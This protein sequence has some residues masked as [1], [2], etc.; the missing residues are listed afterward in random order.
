M[1]NESEIVTASYNG[2]AQ[3][4]I[5]FIKNEIIINNW[6]TVNTADS[7]LYWIYKIFYKLKGQSG[8]YEY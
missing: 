4:S 1:G 8:I 7:P 5:E 2:V 6:N 3:N